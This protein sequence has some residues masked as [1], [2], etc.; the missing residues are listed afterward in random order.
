MIGIAA[1]LLGVHPQTLRL[2]ERE[3]LISPSRTEGNTRLYSQKDIED[4]RTI[5]H[6]TRDVGV[7]LAGV[8][9]IVGVRRRLTQIS[10]EMG[11]MVDRMMR[12]ME[13]EMLIKA[14]LMEPE[15]EEDAD[16]K[17]EGKVVKIKIEKG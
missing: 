4:V 6:L 9:M 1:Q 8:E 2:Y 12:E 11:E 17:R 7:N 16:K 10:S 5:M 13:R 14:G 3:G 15:A